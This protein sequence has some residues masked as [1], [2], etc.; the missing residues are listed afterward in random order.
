VEYITWEST[1]AGSRR[2][3]LL[4][5]PAGALLTVAVLGGAVMT[6]LHTPPAP[7]AAPREAQREPA[8]S[9]A[10]TKDLDAL[11]AENQG[12]NQQVMDVKAAATCPPC[13][14]QAL[15]KARRP[16]QAVAA[17]P[18]VW[19]PPAPRGNPWPGVRPSDR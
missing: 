5:V 11:R 16:A 6:G 13:Q 14:P 8:A 19:S 4:G 18:Q 2:L 7:T 3:F 12:L 10:T 15:P 1:A 17:P 9:Q